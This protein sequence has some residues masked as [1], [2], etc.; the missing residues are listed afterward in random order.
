LVLNHNRGKNLFMRLFYACLTLLSVLLLGQQ[1]GGR[2]V[3]SVAPLDAVVPP[4]NAMLP[5]VRITDLN[6]WVEQG[7]FFVT[8]ICSNESASWQKIWLKM[9]PMDSI[10]N[11]L[12]IT[13]A[14]YAPMATFS[15]AVPPKGR[16]AFFAGWPS[17]ECSGT[18][19]SCRV[20]GAGAIQVSP[21][22]ILLLEDVSGVKML[23]SKQA[24]EAASEEIAWQINGV[25]NNPLSITAPQLR[26]E[27]LLFGTDNLL[28]YST[29]LNPEDPK[30]K[31]IFSLEKDGPMQPGERRRVGV[32]AYYDGMPKA[33][34]TSKIG[35]VE[36]LAFEKR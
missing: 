19:H 9:E 14:R 32:Y 17:S 4:P 1:C 25:L 10:G 8:G 31:K 28:W 20:S 11:P 2:A 15:D 35:R 29:V 5:D 13:G 18:P 30:M 27:L 6:C 7:Q 24:G 21:G 12:T 33:L 34:K 16:T 36:L 22:A 3:P 26:L 23:T